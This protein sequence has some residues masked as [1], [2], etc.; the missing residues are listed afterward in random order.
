MGYLIDTAAVSPDNPDNY[1]ISTAPLSEEEKREWMMERQHPT[2]APAWRISAHICALS[3][4]ERHL[5]HAV[6][7]G[8]RWHAYDATHLNETCD[9]FLCLGNFISLESAKD[10][11]EQSFGQSRSSFRAA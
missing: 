4:G 11:V 6:K 10:A 1:A 2:G 7:V 5:G 3:D 9:G 8:A